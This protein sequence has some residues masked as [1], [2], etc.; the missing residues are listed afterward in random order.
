MNA[1]QFFLVEY[2]SINGIVENIVLNGLSDAQLRQAPAPGQNSLAWLLWHVARSEDFGITVLDGKQPQVL[3]QG[4]WLGRL[5]VTRRDVGTAMTSEECAA[6]NEQ[7]DISGLQAYRTAVATRTRAVI[8]ELNVDQLGEMVNEAHLCAT[9]ADGVIGS[10]RARWLEQFFA[11]HT[12]AWWLGFL[13]WHSAEHLLGEAS[14]VR[15]Q[16]GFPLG[17]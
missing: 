9:F 7:I 6:F 5:H 15:S 11:N 10:E 4:D 1:T 3:S 2:D 12:Q 14:C 17:V 16:N 13:N 8:N